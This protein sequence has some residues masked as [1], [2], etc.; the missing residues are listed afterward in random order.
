MTINLLSSMTT[1]KEEIK[2]SCLLC[3]TDEVSYENIEIENIGKYSYCDNCFQDLVCDLDIE[4]PTYSF[5]VKPR[6]KNSDFDRHIFD[7]TEEFEEWCEDNNDTIDSFKFGMYKS[8]NWSISLQNKWLKTG[9]EDENFYWIHEDDNYCDRDEPE[10][11]LVSL[12]KEGDNRLWSWDMSMKYLTFSAN[13][14]LLDRYVKKLDD[15]ITK[16]TKCREQ[17]VYAISEN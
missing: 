15:K 9:V 17:L 7:T 11:L 13:E 10:K 5:V 3:G 6:R 8:D 14:G 4:P 2:I 1:P 12:Y 16:L